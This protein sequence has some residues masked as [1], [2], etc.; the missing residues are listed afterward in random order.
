MPDV[1]RR[2]GYLSTSKAWYSP[3]LLNPKGPITQRLQTDSQLFEVRNA[4]TG[5]Q[6]DIRNGKP[7]GRS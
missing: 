1:W 5:G 4:L 6:R 7:L 2:T 3:Y